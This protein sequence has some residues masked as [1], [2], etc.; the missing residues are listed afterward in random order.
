MAIIG[1]KDD[2]RELERCERSQKSELICVYGR[3]RVGKTFLIE[4]AFA[5]YFAFR[6]TKKRIVKVDDSAF[7]TG[8]QGKNAV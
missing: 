1:R 2:I 3:K 4:Q 6:A 8:I 5:N 7:H